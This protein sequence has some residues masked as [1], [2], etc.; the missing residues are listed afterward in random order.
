MTGL[1]P[2]IVRNSKLSKNLPHASPLVFSV[3]NQFRASSLSSSIIVHP[4]SVSPSG[5]ALFLMPFFSPMQF[6]LLF[7]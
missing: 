2:T 3:K 1:G 7:G 4:P 5:N 6:N